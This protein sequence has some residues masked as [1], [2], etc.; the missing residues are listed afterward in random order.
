[1]QYTKYTS[2]NYQ[3]HS[4]QQ[5]DGFNVL[6]L[7]H[8]KYTDQETETSLQTGVYTHTLQPD[9]KEKLANEAKKDQEQIIH[10][11]QRQAGRDCLFHT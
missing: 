1:M 5:S 3:P 10:I 11:S 6:D 2:L 8:E 7:K 9:A 4:S